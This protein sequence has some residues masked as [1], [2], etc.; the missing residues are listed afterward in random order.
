[1]E[2]V[3]AWNHSSRSQNVTLFHCKTIYKDIILIIIIL[4]IMTMI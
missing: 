2:P 4:I 3:Y 1:M